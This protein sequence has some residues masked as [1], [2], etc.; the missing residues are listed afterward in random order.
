MASSLEH[1]ATTQAQP[2]PAKEVFPPFDSTNFG[3]LLI[4]LALTFGLLYWLMSRVALPRV[5][6]ILE[7]RHNKINADVLAAHVKR[8]E[9]D[10]AAADYQKTLADA[11]S[12]A[13]SLAQETHARLAAEADAKRHAL[14]AE[15]NARLVAAEKQIEATKAKAMA[16]VDQIAQDTAAAILEHITGKPADPATIADAIAKLKA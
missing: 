6:G 3:S 5:S 12:N 1:T 11:R 4:W 2:A 15:L 14:E 8:K 9:A 10:Q 13:Q 7:A 16:S